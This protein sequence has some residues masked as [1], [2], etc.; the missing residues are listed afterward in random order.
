MTGLMPPLR[1]QTGSAL[2]LQSRPR[3]PTLLRR[4]KERH[5][6]GMKGRGTG[7][8]DSG[9][10]GQPLNSGISHGLQRIEPFP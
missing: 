5:E 4:A 7:T 10:G 1:A 2:A 3:V 9:N 6:M 8:T